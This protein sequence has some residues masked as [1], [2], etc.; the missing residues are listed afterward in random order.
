MSQGASLGHQVGS[1]RGA[2]RK[3]ISKLAEQ[4]D[5]STSY[6]KAWNFFMITAR[7]LLLLYLN[8]G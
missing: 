7:L 8:Y 1:T 5:G 2:K 3:A 4:P 6:T